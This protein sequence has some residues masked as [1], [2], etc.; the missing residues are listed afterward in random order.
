MASNE[1]PAS[2]LPLKVYYIKN[3]QTKEIRKF[4][5]QA[6]S[7]EDF[8]YLRGKICQMFPELREK[9][10]EVFWKGEC[11]RF[12]VFQKVPLLGINNVNHQ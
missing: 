8:E 5:V 2:D 10:I 7:K 12:L 1:A 11:L 4:T 3:Q 9:E 6:T